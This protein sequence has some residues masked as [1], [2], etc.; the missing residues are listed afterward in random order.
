MLDLV[1]DGSGV[2]EDN[3]VPADDNHPA[4]EGLYA[5]I[6]EMTCGGEGLNFT[7]LQSASTTTG[8]IFNRGNRT[9]MYSVQF[10]RAGARDAAR[11][12]LAWLYS[13]QGQEALMANHICLREVTPVRDLSTL[14]G[15][16]MEE[17]SGLD[18]SLGYVETLQQTTNKID[19]VSVDVVYSG[20]QEEEI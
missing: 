13:V 6:K 11:N 3:I 18:I 14:R 1:A 2:D 17:R 20:I 15:T 19:S 4:P 10:M 16:E 5:T 7:N 8:T 9:V 12:F